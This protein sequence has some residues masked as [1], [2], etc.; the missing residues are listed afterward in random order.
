[1]KFWLGSL[2]FCNWPAFSCPWPKLS[3]L[4]GVDM[5]LYLEVAIHTNYELELSLHVSLKMHRCAVFIHTPNGRLLELFEQDVADFVS[6][7]RS[8]PD[9]TLYQ[10][11]RCAYYPH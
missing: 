8:T 3:F 7:Q 2:V 10:L 4:V 1:M 11:R 6:L 5:P 9:R